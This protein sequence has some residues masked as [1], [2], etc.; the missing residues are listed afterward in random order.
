MPAS[1]CLCLY[2]MHLAHDKQKK[3]RRH[4]IDA[5]RL[6]SPKKDSVF[7]TLEQ[8]THPSLGQAVD[9]VPV[10]EK[11]DS[12]GVL[13]DMHDRYSAAQALIS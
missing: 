11:E 13:L 8:K 10:D 12:N 4:R 2:T 7:C 1:L 6:K 3:S 9:G 5:L